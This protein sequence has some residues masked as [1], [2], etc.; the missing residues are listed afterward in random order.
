MGNDMIAEE[1]SKSGVP[2]L[3]VT[4]N[5]GATDEF[6]PGLGTAVS[7]PSMNQRLLVP[8]CAA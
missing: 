8:P 5:T 1:Q 7:A 2:A 4:S 6:A 3:A